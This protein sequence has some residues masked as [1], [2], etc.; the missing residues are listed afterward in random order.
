MR[1]D[2]PAIYK[3]RVATCGSVS[4]QIS[5]SSHKEKVSGYW[6]IVVPRRVDP[7]PTLQVNGVG[8]NSSSA[9]PTTTTT[10]TTMSLSEYT[11]NVH[12]ALDTELNKK[13]KQ[14]SLLKTPERVRRKPVYLGDDE[15]HSHRA[16]RSL[17]SPSPRTD[18]RHRAEAKEQALAEMTEAY[19]GL[20]NSIGED[21]TRPGLLRTP[22]RAA[23]AFL[24]FT[25]GYDEKIAGTFLLFVFLGGGG[26]FICEEVGATEARRNEKENCVQIL[27][28][29]I[30]WQIQDGSAN[31][32]EGRQPIIWSIS[33]K[34]AWKWR[35][36]G[37]GCPPRPLD[38]PMQLLNSYSHKVIYDII[39][40]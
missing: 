36:V 20:I 30:Q 38:Q 1:T 27:D 23:K 25:K 24:Y 10:T 2:W 39:S 31:P 6:M 7:L 40:G 21:P 16:P 26:Y 37:S 8:V 9:L 19:R 3:H 14:L 29:P 17:V 4:C 13:L 35:H 32:R 15:D 5:G 33:P 22:E 18:E 34:T 12:D 28:L 11:N